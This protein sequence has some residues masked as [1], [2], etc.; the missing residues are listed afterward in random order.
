LGDPLGQKFSPNII[1]YVPGD[2]E[3][4]I[5]IVLKIVFIVDN[6]LLTQQILT[7]IEVST[8]KGDHVTPS[9][10]YAPGVWT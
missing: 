7:F 4:D 6:Y 5:R 10:R 2:H 1:N 8:I 3:P 9:Q